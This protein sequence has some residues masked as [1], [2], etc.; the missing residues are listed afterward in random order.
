MTRARTLPARD[1]E[2]VLAT[3]PAL[4]Q[5]LLGDFDSC[6]LMTRFGLEGTPYSNAAQARGIIFHRFAAEVLR[7][8]RVTGEVAI[9]VSEALEIL[10]EVCRQADVPEHEVVTVPAAERRLL[11]IAAIKFAHENTFR[12]DRLIDVERRLEATVSYPHPHTGLPVERVVSGQPDAL[13]ADPPDGA[14]VLDW[15]TT[16]QPPPKYE[17]E[18]QDTAAGVSYLGYFQQ[19]VYALLVMRNY[20]AVQRVTLREFYPLAGEARTA[21]VSTTHIEHIEREVAGL[22]EQLDRALMAGGKSALWHPS[23]GRQCSWCPKPTRCPIEAD[24]RAREGGITSLAQAK[25]AAAEYVVAGTVRERL[26]EALKGWVEVY[27]PVPVKAAKGRYQVRWKRNK[28]GSG[29]TFGVHVPE[30]SDRGPLD[31]AL[32]DKELADAFEQAAARRKAAA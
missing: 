6:R 4:R 11:R 27:G 9:P 28:T 26:H 29:R 23:P 19:R 16:L 15:K 25:R 20:P 17:G 5:S 3:F 31:P 14:V 7:T 12:M 1:F 10:V 18:Q 24:V 30:A 2:T 13:I 8:L 21:T 22:A 32:A